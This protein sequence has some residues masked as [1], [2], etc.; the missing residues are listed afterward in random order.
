MKEYVA[1][2]GLAKARIDNG[3]SQVGRSLDPASAADRALMLLASRAVAV[4]NAVCV[5]AINGHPN[6]ALPLLRSLLELAV[7]ARHIAEAEAE[8]RGAAFLEE[9]AQ[10]DFQ[11]FWRGEKLQ[12]ELERRGF[13]PEAIRRAR[14]L[15]AEHLNA[16]AGGLPWGHVFAERHAKGVAPGEL[17]GL[18]AEA[19][20]QIVRALDERWPGKFEGAEEILTRLK[21]S[22]A[23]D[24]GSPS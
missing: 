11:D 21:E 7:R 1:L 9:A 15:L 23:K 6:E 18:A 4:S 22:R 24:A 5:L 13:A 10:A 17:A 3:F 8:S 2:V 16:N 12:A 19:M 20:A 14:G